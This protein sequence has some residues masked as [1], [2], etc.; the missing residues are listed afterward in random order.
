MEGG[1]VANIFRIFDMPTYYT[2]KIYYNITN[3]SMN[4]SGYPLVQF[5]KLLQHAWIAEALDFLSDA[6]NVYSAQR[7]HCD[8]T[9]VFF[10]RHV[11]K[12]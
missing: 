2:N 4:Y 7:S 12:Y 6:A 1:S 11:V 10:Q 5:S 8:H 3:H 9:T